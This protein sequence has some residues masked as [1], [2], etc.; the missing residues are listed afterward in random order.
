MHGDPTRAT[1]LWVMAIV[2]LFTLTATLAQSPVSVARP[3]YITIDESTIYI[4]GGQDY[5]TGKVIIT[6]QFLS[7]DL[8]QPSW[9]A[10]KPPW[11]PSVASGLGAQ[12][13]TTFGHSFSLSPDQQTLTLLDPVALDAVASN[14]PG[15]SGSF[16]LITNTWTS[17]SVPMQMNQ[18][19]G[20]L[21]AV[22]HPKTGIV[23]TPTGFNN[24]EMAIYD[25][26]T[27]TVSSTPLPP[28]SFGGW[29]FYTFNWNELRDYN[30]SGTTS[31]KSSLYGP[32][33]NPPGQDSVGTLY[34][35]DVPSMTWTQGPNIEPSQNRSQMACTVAGDK[36]QVHPRL[37][38]KATLAMSSTPL[39][40]NLYSNEWTQQ[41]I[42]GS[43]PNSAKPTPM[44]KPGDTNNNAVIAGG[45]AGSLFLLVAIAF[46]LFRKNH[47]RRRR[48]LEVDQHRQDEYRPSGTGTGAGTRFRTDENQMQLFSSMMAESNGPVPPNKNKVY[49][50][51][52]APLHIQQQQQHPN[53][54]SPIPSWPSSS[55]QPPPVKLVASQ[56]QQP[57]PPPPIPVRPPS[58]L[59]ASTPHTSMVYHNPGT[60]MYNFSSPSDNQDYY[61]Q[62][63]NQLAARQRSLHA[64]IANRMSLLLLFE[65]I[66]NYNTLRTR[67]TGYLGTL[68]V[69]A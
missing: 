24:T 52:L 47:R 18:S 58:Y 35:L 30:R 4:Q 12:G 56:T 51:V 16:R 53:S 55:H 42:R 33:G 67:H 50:N 23:Y 21:L 61:Q 64:I 15:V 40:C 29:R 1:S 10:S 43:H 9:D 39:I 66:R 3:A 48:Q 5:T 49:A 31:A 46:L 14:T 38:R 69:M 65:A 32:R 34:I 22:T 17:F 26:S 44:P 41:Y 13:L 59:H 25:F 68:R 6:N 54:T 28:Q 45:A 11:T 20:G 19:E 2:G 7:L 62:L 57:P 37:I 27:H 60:T 8:T 36:H 63:Q